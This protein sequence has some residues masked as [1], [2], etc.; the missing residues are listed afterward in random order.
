MRKAT[1]PIA[2]MTFK[3]YESQLEQLRVYAF[4]QRITQAE[5]VRRVLASFFDEIAK[6]EGV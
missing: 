6:K 4:E 3:L 2:P 5:V 1:Q